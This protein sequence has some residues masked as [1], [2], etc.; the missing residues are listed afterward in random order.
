MPEFDVVIRH[1]T[2]ATASDVFVSDVGIRGGLVVGAEA[3]WRGPY[4]MIKPRGGFP[5]MLNPVDQVAF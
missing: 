2:V 5:G 3:P 1:G 4:E